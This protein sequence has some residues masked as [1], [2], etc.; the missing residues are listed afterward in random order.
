MRQLIDLARPGQQAATLLI[1]LPAAY[2]QPEDF[3]HNGFVAAVRAR[4]LDI[5]LIMAALSF[6]QVCVDS[7]ALEIALKLIQPAVAAGYQSIWLMGISIGGYAAMAY[8]D[9]YPPQ[10]TGMLLI[11][12]YPGNR[13]TTAE[14]AN[15]GGLASWTATAIAIDDTERRNWRWLQTQG[16]SATALELY[17]AYG[18]HDRFAPSYVLMAQTM[19]AARVEHIAGGHSW[20]VWL[21]LWQQFLDKRFVNQHAAA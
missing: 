1:L 15:A 20:P 5:D 3:I 7:A 14:I 18:E 2:Q 21:Q 11:A 9:T 4:A 16:Q 8:A 17:L 19:P 13:M 12:P 10:L 6:D